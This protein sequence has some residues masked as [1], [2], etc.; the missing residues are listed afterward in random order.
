[1]TDTT[2]EADTQLATHAAEL[3]TAGCRRTL[4]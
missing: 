3:V 1:M 2:N 4:P